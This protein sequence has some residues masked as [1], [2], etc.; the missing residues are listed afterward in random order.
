MTRDGF[1]TSMPE[2]NEGGVNELKPYPPD[3]V[4]GRVIDSLCDPGDLKTLVEAVDV[5]RGTMDPDPK[6]AAAARAALSSRN[7]VLLPQ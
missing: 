4:I 6:K 5:A 2:G 7:L 3:S 1:L